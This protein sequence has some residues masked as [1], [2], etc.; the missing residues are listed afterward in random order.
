MRNGC[1]FSTA[2][3]S[4]S[5]FKE[6]SNLAICC[7]EK[8]CRDCSGL[9]C[10][11][12]P[13]RYSSARCGSPKAA[14]GQGNA[15]SQGDSVEQHFER[16]E[17][18][19][20]LAGNAELAASKAERYVPT[21]CNRSILF[22]GICVCGW[23]VEVSPTAFAQVLL[24]KRLCS[25]VLNG[26]DG[27]DPRSLRPAQPPHSHLV[28]CRLAAEGRVVPPRPQHG[29]MRVASDSVGAFVFL[30]DDAWASC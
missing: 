25:G 29:A 17:N 5:P 21:C 26:H 6:Q 14:A 30:L 4:T 28:S 10:C 3:A 20:G 19:F 11:A 7:F 27:K 15:P 8:R 12:L 13:S 2:P 18:E 16:L 24:W 23:M 1:D 9:V 22:C